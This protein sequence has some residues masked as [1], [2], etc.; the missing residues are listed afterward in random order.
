MTTTTSPLQAAFRAVMAD[1]VPALRVLLDADDAIGARSS[2]DAG[3]GAP[4]TGC[5]SGV[6]AA[7]LKLVDATNKGGDTLEFLAVERGR[8]TVAAFLRARREAAQVAQ[9]SG[10]AEGA[11]TLPPP[12]PPPPQ[13]HQQDAVLPFCHPCAMDEG[14]ATLASACL[15]ATLAPGLQAAATAFSSK[16]GGSPS[17]GGGGAAAAEDGEG[18]A[19]EETASSSFSSFSSSSSSS[20]ASSSSTAALDPGVEPRPSLLGA[21]ILAWRALRM[22]QIAPS[23]FP[24]SS[25]LP[26][27]LV[28]SFVLASKYRPV[29][30]PRALRHTPTPR[31]LHRRCVLRHDAADCRGAAPRGQIV[32]DARGQPVLC[33]RARARACASALHQRRAQ[34]QLL[35]RTPCSTTRCDL[36]WPCWRGGWARSRARARARGRGR[37]SWW[38]APCWRLPRLPAPSAAPQQCVF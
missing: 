29:R 10:S 28:P 3:A 34:Q 17:S 23:V 38:G 22:I 24:S 5:T 13:Q 11:G 25:R 2:Q 7:R 37:G 16:T 20:S 26:R 14:W 30:W 21:S 6:C 33:R 35:Y 18:E 31:R 9:E 1:D 19:A 32:P 12:R 8:P 15:G 36:L 27:S 4:T